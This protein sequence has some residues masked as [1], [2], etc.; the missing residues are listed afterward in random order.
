MRPHDLRHTHVALLIAAGE[1]PY[2]ISQRLGHASICPTYDVYGHLLEGRDREAADALEAARARSLADFPRTPGG[3]KV[4]SLD[5]QYQEIP[6]KHR[7]HLV[8]ELEG[9]E[10]STSCMPCKRSAELSYSPMP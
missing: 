9:F 4:V 10:P 7:G 1:D 5:P 8:V 2:L 3:S 6:C